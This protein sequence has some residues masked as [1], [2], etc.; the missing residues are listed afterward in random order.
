M[1]ITKVQSNSVITAGNNTAFGST[2][3]TLTCAF[4]SNNTATNTLIVVATVYCGG[5]SGGANLVNSPTLTDS[6]GNTYTQIYWTDSNYQNGPAYGAWICT[7][8]A[9]GANTVTFKYWATN[10]NVPGTFF[11]NA[12]AMAVVEYPITGPTVQSHNQVRQYAANISPITLTD[13][14]S[15]TVSVQ[16]QDTGSWNDKGY[17]VIDLLS[18]GINFLICA[19]MGQGSTPIGVPTVTPVSYSAFVQQESQSNGVS[20]VDRLYYWDQAQLVPTSIDVPVGTLTLT[21]FAPTIGTGATL[22]VPVGSLILT[23]FVPIVVQGTNFCS[24]VPPPSFTPPLTT[25]NEPTE[26]QGS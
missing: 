12:P 14:Q 4:S 25:K 24:I 16:V 22:D 10:S 18:S 20:N 26:L 7:N 21:G 9:A 11:Y 1:S 13:S 3:Y 8:C 23:G 6:A 19:G 2:Q 5:G 15:N 17:I